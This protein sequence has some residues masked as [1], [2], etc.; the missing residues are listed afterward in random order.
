MSRLHAGIDGAS[1]ARDRRSGE[2]G[3]AS[4]ND[5]DGGGSS[6]TSR[7]CSSPPPAPSPPPPVTAL[8]SRVLSRVPSRVLIHWLLHLL[9]QEGRLLT[10]L[11]DFRIDF[12]RGREIDR[13]DCYDCANKRFVVCKV[14]N[15]SRRGKSQMFGRF[16]KCSTCN[17]NG[18]MPCPSCNTA[19]YERAISSPMTNH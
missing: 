8:L 12:Q 17:E 14:C 16:L 3:S 9:P 11:R 15:G 6:C 13:K 18:L 10:E 19:D 4:G 5:Q 7:A 1:P 2:A